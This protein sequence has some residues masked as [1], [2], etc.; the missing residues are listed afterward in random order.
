MHL[1]STVFTFNKPATTNIIVII[2]IINIIAVILSVPSWQNIVMILQSNCPD[3]TYGSASNMS[4]FF[5]SNCS[6]DILLQ[7]KTKKQPKFISDAVTEKKNDGQPLGLATYV[8][9]WAGSSPRVTLFPW[10]SLKHFSQKWYL[11]AT[12]PY[13]GE[14][15]PAHT[16]AAQANRRTGGRMQ[17]PRTEH[18]RWTDGRTRTH[19]HTQITH[20]SRGTR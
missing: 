2:I 16:V 17:Q 1:S 13:F 11:S 9:G 12:R 3:S 19:T 10:I 15:Q 5:F 6:F 18:G 8:C 7:I 14:L 20:T 4:F